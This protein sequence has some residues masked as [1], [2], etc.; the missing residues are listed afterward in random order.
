MLTIRH[1]TRKSTNRPTDQPTNRP[2]VHFPTLLTNE[3][4]RNQKKQAY[5]QDIMTVS[6]FVTLLALMAPSTMAYVANQ[7]GVALLNKAKGKVSTAPSD[8]VRIPNVVSEETYQS[9]MDKPQ[10]RRIRYDLGLGKNEP[11]VDRS[12]TKVIP[13]SIG[14]EDAR[15]NN[16]NGIA[17]HGNQYAPF[18]MVHDSTNIFPTPMTTSTSS[19]TGT[20]ATAPTKKPADS[21]PRKS[22]LVPIIPSRKTKDVLKILTGQDKEGSQATIERTEP[23]KLDLNTIWVEMLIHDQQQQL[24][25]A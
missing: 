24:Q 9:S 4:E 3:R 19:Q 11:V 13:A 15:T 22:R 12:T 10:K 8:F 25:S 20:A 5:F 6:V 18:W 21:K 1:P 16:H 14:E 23:V 17:G 2:T 7:A